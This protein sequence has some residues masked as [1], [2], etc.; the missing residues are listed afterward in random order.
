M[1]SKYSDKNVKCSSC[2]YWYLR[3][4]ADAGSPGT[5]IIKPKGRS[6]GSRCMSRDKRGGMH[7]GICLLFEVDRSVWVFMGDAPCWLDPATAWS[8][9]NEQE[10]S[11]TTPALWYRR[12]YTAV[13]HLSTVSGIDER[14]YTLRLE[15]AGCKSR[16]LIPAC[17]ALASSSGRLRRPHIKRH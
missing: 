12:Y 10:I 11:C 17:L 14:P 4:G 6:T 2:T 1:D 5:V 16:L 3:I 15:L 9:E 13:I 7:L 8:G